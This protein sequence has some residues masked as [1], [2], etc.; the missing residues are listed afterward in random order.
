MYVSSNVWS[1][2]NFTREQDTVGDMNWC[3]NQ[4]NLYFTKYKVA[5]AM[6]E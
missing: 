5:M 6:N 4:G 2:P 3:G 1:K